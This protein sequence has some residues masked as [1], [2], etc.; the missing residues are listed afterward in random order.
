MVKLQAKPFNI[1]MIQVYAPTQD[2]DDEAIEEFYEQIQ[3]AVTY[4]KSSDIICIMLEVGNVKDSKFI[5]NYGLG[6]QNERG[7]RLNRIL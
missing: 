6:E 5:G 7:Q 4:M 2:Y 1:K 3:S